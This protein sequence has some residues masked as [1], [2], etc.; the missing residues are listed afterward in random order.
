MTNDIKR[1][2]DGRYRLGWYLRGALSYE[3]LMYRISHEDVE[4]LNN[5]AKENIEATEKSGLSLI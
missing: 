4:I 1:I 3:D 2:K 5:I